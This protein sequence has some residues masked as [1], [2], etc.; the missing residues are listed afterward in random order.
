MASSDAALPACGRFR[1]IRLIVQPGDS[2]FPIVD[3]LDEAREEIRLTVFR[4]D[5]PV[6]RGAL[7]AARQRGVKVRVLISQQRKG[8]EKRNAEL[9]D[10]LRSHGVAAVWPKPAPGR[11]ICGYHYKVMTVDGHRTLIFTFNPTRTNLHYCRDFGLAIEDRALAAEV[12]RMLDLDRLGQ[13]YAPALPC[14][15][16]SPENARQKLVEFFAGARESIHVFDSRLEDFAVHEVLRRKAAQGVDVRVI[17][18]KDKYALR[19]GNSFFRGIDR[20]QLHAKAAVVDRHRFYVGSVNLRPTALDQRRELAIFVHDARIGAAL[21]TIFLED[22]RS[23]HKGEALDATVRLTT[24][25]DRRAMGRTLRGPEGGVC[26]Y[27]LISRVNATTQYG[28]GD[29]TLEIGRADANDVVIRH[30]TVSRRHA[31]IRCT[32]Q[33]AEIEDLDT[34]N[35]TL[36]NREPLRATR[37]LELGDVITVAE[38]E[39]FRFVEP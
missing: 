33:C 39:E 7:I 9:L 12:N 25:A 27:L 4:L 17:G 37:R 26:R 30:P 34:A 16:V 14:L 11:R 2:F 10:E 19:E 38:G 5:C 15:G 36:V 28:I 3:A 32:G 29:G 21:E 18:S 20:F 8:R 31:L 13:P 6:V 24:T 1:D 23:G 35:G 22:W